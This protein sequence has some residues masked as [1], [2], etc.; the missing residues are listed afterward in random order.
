VSDQ[1][2]GFGMSSDDPDE[3]GDGGTGG[4]NPFAAFGFGPGDLNAAN[5][6]AMLEQVGRMLQSGGEGPVNWQLAHDT[7][8]QAVAARGDASVLRT[9]REAVDEAVR[10]AEVWLDPVTALPAGTS[11]ALAWSRAEWVEGTLP[12]WKGLIEPLAARMAE[13]STSALPAE[14]QAMAGPMLGM[15][16]Q[17][18]G[19]MVGAQAGQALGQLAGEVVGSTDIGLPLGPEG[20][21]VLVPV[22]VRSYAEGL[23][24]PEDEVRLHLALR[25]CAHQR[26]FAHVPWLRGAL[27]DAVGAY[28][29]GITFDS[30]T[31]RDRMGSIDPN[32]PASIQGALES[33]LFEPADTPAQSAALERL[34]TLL[35]L[36]EGWVD[37]VVEAAATPALPHAVA[38]AETARRRRAAG[39]PAE[40]TF[41]ALVG[42]Q[43][44]P[45]RMREAAE[46]W[47]QLTE[48]LG[49]DGRDAVWENPL[50]LPGPTDLAEPAAYVARRASVDDEVAG[51]EIPDDLSG[52][53]DL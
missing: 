29:A 2:F 16:Q 15:F 19:A 46:V 1:P 18:G 41:A 10:L 4:G 45:R 36:V 50:G 49:S 25:E 40:A 43:L 5:L 8:R 44:R 31:L 22:N 27:L 39:G 38:L 7:A 33:G 51:L 14:A 30:D 9:E 13:A 12:V 23:G 20:K 53:D 26:L 11:S 52:L 24:V 37:V 28:A 3:P 32:D 48:A 47:R 42:L 17:L 21:A 34:E 35:A 6:G